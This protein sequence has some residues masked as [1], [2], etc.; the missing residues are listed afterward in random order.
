MTARRATPVGTLSRQRLSDDRHAERDAMRRATLIILMACVVA[1]RA[2][3]DQ[4]TGISFADVARPRP[5]EWPTYNGNLSGNRFSPLDQIN[6]TTIHSLAPKWMFT[7]HG[8][9]ACASDDADCRR[10]RHVRH[11]G[12]RSVRTRCAKRKVIWHYSRPRTQGLAGDAATGIN[13]GVAVLGDRVFT[14]SRTTLT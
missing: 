5:G 2:R 7:I 13:R 4:A 11:V 12:E 10:R 3:T 1:A 6:A 9:P 14:R 8:S